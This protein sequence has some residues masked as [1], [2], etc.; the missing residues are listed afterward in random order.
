MGPSTVLCSKGPFFLH[1]TLLAG[2]EVSYTE[3]DWRS[4]MFGIWFPPTGPIRASVTV[5]V[6]GASALVNQ[7]AKALAAKRAAGKCEQ[8]G[9]RAWLQAH[10]LHYRTVG[11]EEAWDLAMLCAPCHR[12]AHRPPWL[13]GNY[14]HDT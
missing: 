12:M 14:F 8:C 4:R 1:G 9:L 10:H 3:K 5:F 6:D 11:F 7:N 2:G 13:G